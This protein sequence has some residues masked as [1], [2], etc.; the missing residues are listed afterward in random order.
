MSATTA[1]Y[2]DGV[3]LPDQCRFCG[4]ES[5][6]ASAE[7]TNVHPHSH[8]GEHVTIIACED[9]DGA[10]VTRERGNKRRTTVADR[11]LV[12]QYWTI[13]EG[14]CMTVCSGCGELAGAHDLDEERELLKAIY[15]EEIT[16]TCCDARGK[17]ATG[18]YEA[19]L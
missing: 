6:T 18:S 1:R 11:T 10:L 13:P 8:D 12:A 5:M 4:S 3:R 15:N 14:Y 17:F 7:W 16:T 19:P 9:C 2:Q